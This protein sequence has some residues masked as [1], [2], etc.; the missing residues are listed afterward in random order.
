[1]HKVRYES[2]NSGGDWWLSDKDWRN[3]EAAGWVVA[4]RDKR[5][6]AALAT[7]ATLIAPSL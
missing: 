6:L 5:F 2:N 3:L 4:W 7:E 1:M